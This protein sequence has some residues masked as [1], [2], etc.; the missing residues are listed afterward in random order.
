MPLHSTWGWIAWLLDGLIDRFE[1]SVGIGS[2]SSAMALSGEA[3]RLFGLPKVLKI[4]HAPSVGFQLKSAPLQQPGPPVAVWGHWSQWA[5]MA[6][7]STP[8]LA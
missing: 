1:G 3:T 5:V 2:C 8:C 6:D 4:V 7:A